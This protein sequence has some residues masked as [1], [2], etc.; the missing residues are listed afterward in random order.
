MASLTLERF[1]DTKPRG[2][3]GWEAAVAPDDDGATARANDGRRS[4]R[5]KFVMTPEPS[6]K[7]DDALR[8][9]GMRRRSEVAGRRG[10]RSALVLGAAFGGLC[11]AAL[12]TS[13][14]QA[15]PLDPLSPEE[16]TTA[17]DVL[18][19]AGLADGA[20][21]Y[22]TVELVE[23]AKSAVLSWRPGQASGRVAHVA[24]QRNDGLH[25]AEVDLAARRI[26][27]SR[28]VEGA[29]PGLF[30]EE[31]GLATRLTVQ[32]P[33]WQAAMRRRGYTAFDSVFC[34]PLTVG[35]FDAPEDRGRR[36]LR[37]PCYDTTG[38][39]TTVHGRPIEGLLAVVDLGRQEV[40]RVIDTGAVPVP[41]G[42]NRA[43]EEF[44]ACPAAGHAP[45]AAAN[46]EGRQCH[47]RRAR[48]RLGPLALPP[49]P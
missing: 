18:R 23:P 28:K 35:H 3:P 5:R 37:V 11:S 7:S 25:E 4:K 14:A 1:R 24:M 47:H 6:R 34:A 27:A 46:A 43:D 13:G 41:P 33:E 22:A 45:G 49:A 19:G 21:R 40:V 9:T 16:I 20:T 17:G 10:L 2:F 32:S 39:R 15:H 48:G 38:G 29:Q 44:A 26:L 36:L 42:P 8:K 12:S 30:P 31:F